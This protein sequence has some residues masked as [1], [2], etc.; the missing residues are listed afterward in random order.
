MAG[1]TDKFLASKFSKPPHPKDGYTV[2]DCASKRDRRVL[3]F[4][5]PILYPERPTRITVTLANKL[6]GALS[7]DRKVSWG[8]VIRDLVA[9][10]VGAVG[11]SKP[12]GLTSFLFH[13]YYSLEL[14]RARENTVYKAALVMLKYDISPPPELESEEKKEEKEGLGGRGS[15]DRKREEKRIPASKKGKGPMVED[16]KEDLVWSVDR[17]PDLLGKIVADLERIRKDQSEE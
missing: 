1:R 2:A 16:V 8:I 11:K 3:E 15:S 5:T 10:M 17:N 14:L 6:F 13:L 4:L 12:S 9:K 7:G